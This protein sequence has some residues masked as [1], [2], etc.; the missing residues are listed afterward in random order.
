MVKEVSNIIGSVFPKYDA[1]MSQTPEWF[2][3]VFPIISLVFLVLVVFVYALLIWV[4]YRF[5][6]RKNVVGL[7]LVER[8]NLEH[9]ILFKA[10]GFF[11]YFLENVIISPLLVFLGFVV[12]TIFLIF[13]NEALTISQIL[14]ISCLVIAVIRIAAYYNNE[15]SKELAKLLPLTLLGLSLYNPQGINFNRVLES[16]IGISEY[17]G[18]IFIYLGFIIVLEVFLRFLY[19]IFGLFSPE[20]IQEEIEEKESSKSE[21]K[22]EK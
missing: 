1:I 13:L 8:N 18:E 20:E 9:S 6:A 5:M 3:S 22:V 10:F 21:E 2:Q 12:F 14:L 15:F 19:F 11:L 4:F 7:N 16:F 17:I